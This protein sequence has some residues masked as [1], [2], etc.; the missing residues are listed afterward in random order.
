MSSAKCD[1]RENPWLSY[2]KIDYKK[3]C[4]EELRQGGGPVGTLAEVGTISVIA[5]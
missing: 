3:K 2:H 5:L 1:I 4:G